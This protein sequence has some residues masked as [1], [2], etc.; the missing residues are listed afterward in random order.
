MWAVANIEI[1]LSKSP[2]SKNQINSNMCSFDFKN[3]CL[4]EVWLHSSRRYTVRR[5]DRDC[6]T[7]LRVGGASVAA[8]EAVSALNVDP[9]LNIMKNVPWHK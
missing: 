9:T 5:S 2:W 3:A 4:T 8:S 6:R 7:E 1:F